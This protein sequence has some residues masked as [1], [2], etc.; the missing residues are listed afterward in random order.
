MMRSMFAAISGLKVHQTMLDVTANDIANVNTLGYKSQPHDVQGL[1]VPA[2]AR[3][4]RRRA[5]QGGSNAVQVGLGVAARLDRQ[6]ACRPAPCRP[7]ATRS[8]SRSRATALPRRD[9]S[10]AAGAG[11]TTTS[12]YTR[13]GNFTRNDAGLPGHAGR[14]VRH[15]PHGRRRRGTDTLMQHPDRRDEHRR[16][17][18]TA[19]SPTTD[20]RRR[21]RDR[22]LPLARDVRERRPASSAFR[23]PLAASRATPAA[24][25]VGTPGGSFGL[26]DARRRSR[27]R[28]STSPRS[29]RT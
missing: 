19:R 10:P 5:R 13:A 17:A 22:G 29:S 2:A 14:P 7:R 16:S 9:A 4:L 21:P 24:E 6:P 26:D 28:T 8:T 1:A 23:Q 11:S 27:C 20:R 25:S 15:R 3:R 18:R 12:E